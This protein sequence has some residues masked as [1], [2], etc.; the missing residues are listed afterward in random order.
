MNT[1]TLLKEV[2]Q[3]R[4]AVKAGSDWIDDALYMLRRYLVTHDNEHFTF[5][6]FRAWALTQGLSEP[7]SLNA[8]GSLPRIAKK[9]GLCFPTSKVEP[10]RRAASHG[11]IVR[12]WRAA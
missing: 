6:D 7:E 12:V 10:A 9:E 2:G 4:A 5:D 11:R 3:H 1:A 8:W